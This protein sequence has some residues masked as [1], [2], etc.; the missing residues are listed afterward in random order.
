MN[1]NRKF[2]TN[3]RGRKGKSNDNRRRV[4]MHIDMDAFFAAVEQAHMPS[5]EGKA[6]IIGGDPRYR[7]VVTTCSYE[8]RKFGVHSA[9]SS[10]EALKRCPHGIFINNAT[11]KY[12]YVSMEIMK[13]LTDFSPQVEPFSVDEA[14][15]DI[16]NTS[17]RW[18]GPEQLA[19]E[20]KRRIW[21]SQRMTASI[22]ISAVR[23]VAKMAS[24]VNKPDGLT[25]VEPGKEKEFLWPQ[26]IGNLWGVG[27]K[28]QEAFQK[29]GINTIGDLA[30]CP[31]H[32]LKK[33]FGIVG[34]S[35]RDMANGMGEN[36]ICFTCDSS[37]DKSMGHERTFGRDTSDI[38]EIQGTLLHLA[39]KV[40][41][42]LRH[43]GYRGRTITLKIKHSDIK[44]K[45]RANTIY[46]PTDCAV[47][48]YNQAKSLLERNGFLNR[49]IR[50]IGVSVS[51]LE[52][53]VEDVQ[54]DLLNDP[55]DSR[56]A[57]VDN[58]IDK[59]RDKYGEDT[60]NFAGTLL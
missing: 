26:P 30:K 21:Q 4:I 27:P 43:A 24:G 8:A 15:L 58:V 1:P 18:G 9:M 52:K 48:I 11:S 3:D 45:T 51:K 23:F 29:I 32:H 42:R 59:L 20:V 35:L 25:V 6:V 54:A 53:V 37:D 39:D 44:L 57:K 60:I 56:K 46:R 13:I 31:K 50:L 36:D 41:R 55:Q 33:Y 34:D 38:N 40:S 19:M 28:S 12:S 17:P 16:T 5:L 22:G 49:P 7:G 47:D 2:C 14:F 10:A